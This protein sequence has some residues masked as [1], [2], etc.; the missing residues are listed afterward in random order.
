MAASKPLSRKEA[1]RR[2]PKMIMRPFLCYLPY[3][4]DDR[5]F[6]ALEPEE[7]LLPALADMISGIVAVFGIIFLSGAL[8]LLVGTGHKELWAFF[9]GVPLL[10]IGGMGYIWFY[11]KNV[12]D[13][14]SGHF[15]VFDRE[16]GVVHAGVLENGKRRMRTFPFEECH[17]ELSSMNT[18][19]IPVPQYTVSIHH[20]S[21][22][23][24]LHGELIGDLDGAL[25]HW[26]FLVQYM[27]KQ[28]P[29][30]NVGYLAGYPNR[31][32]G[33]GP[34]DQWEEIRERADFT[35]PYYY[36]KNLCRF[37][38]DMGRPVHDKPPEQ[39]TPRAQKRLDEPGRKVPGLRPVLPDRLPLP[40]ELLRPFV[41]TKTKMADDKRYHCLRML[42]KGRYYAMGCLTLLCAGFGLLAA[43]WWAGLP[44]IVIAGL[45]MY[46]LWQAKL[47]RGLILDRENG[48]IILHKGWL[49]KPLVLPFDQCR[50]LLISEPHPMGFTTSRLY[51]EHPRLGLH[52]M[53]DDRSATLDMELG[54]W[55]MLVQY[56]DKTRPLPSWGPFKDFPGT[57]PGLGP[58]EEWS[59]RATRPG[60]VDPLA[61]W[62]GRLAQDQR[63]DASAN[64]ASEAAGEAIPRLS[65]KRH[66]A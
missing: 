49:L 22:P 62:L 64:K 16:K 52:P 7:G 46:G 15:V 27:D 47:T 6:V 40:R 12:Y 8:A 28:A 3:H 19:T 24:P 61:K 50:G 25:G 9:W 59:A 10:L 23:G 2:L 33:V 53:E 58:W 20:P 32:D 44:V 5:T 65:V 55:S 43:S 56:L 29:L 21:H 35:D 38:R 48:Q 51:L 34:L 4:V 14:K 54:F 17:G 57:D 36:W 13:T 66:P 18:P 45:A 11:Y 42:E 26:S 1:D 41:Y 30:P 60:F 37:N 39:F 63:R 31:T